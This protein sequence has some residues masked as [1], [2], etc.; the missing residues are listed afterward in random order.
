MEQPTLETERLVLRPFTAADAGAV[1]EL[2]GDIDVARYT[3][4]IPHPYTLEDAETWIAAQPGALEREQRVTYAVTLGGSVVGAVGLVLALEHERGELG[5]WIGRPYWGR[6][7]ATEAAAAVVDWAFR[8]LGLRRVHASHF[9]DNPPSGR[10][11][12]KLGMRHEGTARQ[13]IRKWDAFLDVERY[14]LLRDD[15]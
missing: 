3:L 6:G 12:Q 7:F 14:G 11:L 4:H 2:A 8:E 13:H 5:Y 1:R 9:R 15:R 10:V